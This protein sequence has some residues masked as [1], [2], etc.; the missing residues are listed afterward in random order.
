MASH[1]ITTN[2]RALKKQAAME[3]L[4]RECLRLKSPFKHND[5]CNSVFTAKPVSTG[6]S[7]MGALAYVGIGLAG[8]AVLAPI[9]VMALSSSGSQG[10][11]GVGQINSK[12]ALQTMQNASD[13]GDENAI[14]NAIDNGDKTSQGLGT[15]ITSNEN[16]AKQAKTDMDTVKGKM[17]TLQN[18]TIPDLNKDLTK[19]KGEL[20]QFQSELDKLHPNGK[21]DKDYQAKRTELEQK[22]RDK[23][24]EIENKQKAI[25]DA[26][27]QLQD[28]KQVYDNK[29]STY[30]SA[31]DKVNDL[32]PE[33]E[34]VDAELIRL[35]E[36]LANVQKAT[37][38]DG[39][40]AAPATAAAPAVSVAT[41]GVGKTDTSA[42]SGTAASEVKTPAENTDK[43]AVKSAEIPAAKEAPPTVITISE[44][45]FKKN[46]TEFK[47]SFNTTGDD[48]EALTKLSSDIDSY[49]KTNAGKFTPAQE[50]EL[51][52][53]K[54]D[55]NNKVIAKVASSGLLMK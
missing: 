50:T 30:E 28:F 43:A 10:P 6:S 55:I 4:D 46:L 12:A 19:L 32:K 39:A 8:A 37:K 16:T 47:T 45:D 29:K 14:K 17:D 22:I 2:G 53:V 51:A 18:T 52:T 54:T 3:G 26:E 35:R 49:S 44:A 11:Q 1:A 33:K 23:Q 21:E 27:N 15:Q 31:T 42:P 40:T 24:T 13:S 38:P 5:H 7:G 25:K 48:F 36:K 41:A 34:K 20:N 9:A